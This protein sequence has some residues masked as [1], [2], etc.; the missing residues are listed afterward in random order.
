MQD[1]DKVLVFQ[2]FARKAAQRLEER[3][4]MRREKLYVKSIEDEV[5]IRGLSDAELNDC[6]E[7]S[8]DPLEVDK[9]TV[10]YA[11]PTLQEAGKI[12]VADGTLKQEYKIMDMF[13]TPERRYLVNR[14]LELSGATGEAGIEP[15]KE[16]E[17]LKN[18]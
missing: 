3:K 1:K 16:T 7:F 6:M 5:E 11:S 9:Y 10:Y 2:N 15:V 17:E 4:K 13:T 12:L 18:S 14:V 8:E